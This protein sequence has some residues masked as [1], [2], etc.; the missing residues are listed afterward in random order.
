MNDRRR[1]VRP[2]PLRQTSS[3]P[4]HGVSAPPAVRLA[5]VGQIS[6]TLAAAQRYAEFSG[7]LIEGARKELTALLLEARLTRE[8]GERQY[9]RARARAKNID[10]SAITVREGPL[11]VVVSISARGYSGAAKLGSARTGAGSR[12]RNAEKRAKARNGES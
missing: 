8:E 6:V 10:I 5:H 7:Q 12:A 2:A 4:P 1:D 3:A 11:V 9:W